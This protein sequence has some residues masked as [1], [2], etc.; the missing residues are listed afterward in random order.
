M[1]GS[2]GEQIQLENISAEKDIGVTVDEDLNFRTH[3]QL[4]VNKASSIAGL[5]RRIFVYLDES[6]FKLLFKSPS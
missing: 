6:M 4:I 3:I 1:T 2:G 5:I